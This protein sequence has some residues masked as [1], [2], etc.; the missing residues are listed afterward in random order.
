MLKHI[1]KQGDRKIAII[2]REVPGEEHMALVSYPDILPQ[3]MH[4]GLMSAIESTEGQAAENLADALASK[5][6]PDGTVQLQRLHNEGMIKKVRAQ[7]I[8]VTPTPQASTHVRLD[9]LNK[10]INEMNSGTDAAQRLA[11]LDAQAGMTG[12]VNPKD[13]YGREVGGPRNIPRGS[14]N[15]TSNPGMRAQ[16]MRAPQGGALSD[17][18]IANNLKEQAE[19]MAAQAK[20][21]VAESERLIAEASE[22]LGETAPK[23]RG[24]PKKSAAA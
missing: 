12:T 6:F 4:D 9:E 21:L 24:R 17:A 20:Q 10:I 13:D 15:E 1:G 7:D 8:M 16:T 2:F 23:K 14:L 5:M 22:M 11:D 18:D 3:Q 19:Q